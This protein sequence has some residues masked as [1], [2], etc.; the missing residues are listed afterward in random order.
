MN[1][2][3]AAVNTL[4]ETGMTVAV[5]QEDREDGVDIHIHVTR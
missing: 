3:N 2:I 5:E 4:R 1:T